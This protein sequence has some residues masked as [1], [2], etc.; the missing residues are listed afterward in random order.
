MPDSITLNFLFSD[1]V[2]ERNDVPFAI[3]NVPD[4]SDMMNCGTQNETVLKGL[5]WAEYTSRAIPVPANFKIICSNRQ[6]AAIGFAVQLIRKKY[7]E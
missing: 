7:D 5:T 2:T 1:E 4:F 6:I 3:I